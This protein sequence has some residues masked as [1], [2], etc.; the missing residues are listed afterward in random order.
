MTLTPIRVGALLQQASRDE[1]D[2]ASRKG[3][4]ISVVPT[5]ASILSD[6]LLLDAVLRNL[7]RNA[8]KYTQPG[9]RILLGCRHA[10]AS[11]R[12]DMYDSGA[13]IVGEHMPIIFEAFTCFEPMRRDSL[14][15]GLFI[16]RQAIGI[17]G[18]RIEL[19]STFTRGSRFSI[20]ATRAE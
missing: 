8:V 4:S 10:G 5:N 19:A 16:V 15:M 7:V 14:G 6:A 9:G 17:L 18:H 11:V 12:I 20:F 3:I 2:A 13:G 1:E